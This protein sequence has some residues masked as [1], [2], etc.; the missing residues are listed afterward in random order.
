MEDDAE[1]HAQAHEDDMQDVKSDGGANDNRRGVR[2][3]L[4]LSEIQGT[5][6]SLLVNLR[7]GNLFYT[8]MNSP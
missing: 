7:C 4:E 8:I 2:C 1:P 5:T 3:P 6:T